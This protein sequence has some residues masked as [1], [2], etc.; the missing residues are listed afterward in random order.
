MIVNY[1]GVKHLVFRRPSSASSGDA[2]RPA[3]D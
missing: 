2:A 1:F 3:F